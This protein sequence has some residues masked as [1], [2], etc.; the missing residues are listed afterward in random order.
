[1][2]EQLGDTRQTLGIS[3]ISREEYEQ[4]TRNTSTSKVF[5]SSILKMT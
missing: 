4:K 1:M 3:P 5:A 2:E